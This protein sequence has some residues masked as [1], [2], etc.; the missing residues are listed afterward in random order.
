MGQGKHLIKG[1]L[2][3]NAHFVLSVS[4]MFFMMPF[5]IRSLGNKIYGIWI[6]VG[7]FIGYYGLLDMGLS[8]AVERFMSRA[9]GR[10]D[11]TAANRIISTS[12]VMFSTGGAIVLLLSSIASALCFYLIRDPGDAV[13]F[14][15][16]IFILGIGMAIRL[17]MKVF[18]GVLISHLRY[19]L[20][21]Y[22]S[23]LKLLAANAFIFYFL[24]TGHGVLA[25]A[26][27]TFLANQLE[28]LLELIFAKKVFPE[29][30][31]SRSLYQKDEVRLLLGYSVKTFIARLADIL[32]FRVDSFVIAIFLN[33]SVITPYYVAVRLVDYFGRFITNSVGLMMPVFSRYESQG[34]YDL[35]R[36]KFLDVTRISTV[37]SVFVGAS[38]IYYGNVFICRWMG[39]GFR[40]SYT[41]LIILCVPVMIGLMQNPSLGLL[42]GISKHH[43]FSVANALE[44]VL[45]LILSILLVRRYG[46]YGV[47]LGTAIP[48]MLFKLFVM[49]IYS[50]RVIKV[51]VYEYYFKTLF[52]SGIKTLCPLLL[53]FY[54]GRFF[55]KADYANIIISGGIQILLFVPI[56]FYFVFGERER[57]IILRA[58]GMPGA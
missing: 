16:M 43:F 48:L 17:P 50:C 54:I 47:A 58:I 45:N 30:R 52:L 4:I 9:L 19:D 31:I 22:A 11:I 42:Y 39:P 53:Y 7:T 56:L 8:S 14:G 27:I 25:L 55:L 49:P 38:M 51:P 21:T 46:I 2:I 6:L 15:K 32:R 40:S 24:K 10:R 1:S 26:V 35:M 5:I 41:I 20:A 13:L 34:R 28:Y 44:G 57:K 12:F 36:Q 37:L 29:L 3:R 33:L 18:R 23:M